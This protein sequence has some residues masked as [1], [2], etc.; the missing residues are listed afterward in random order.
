MLLSIKLSLPQS[1]ISNNN[2]QRRRSRHGDYFWCKGHPLSDSLWRTTAENQSHRHI[3][4]VHLLESY[5][6]SVSNNNGKY[7]TSKFKNEEDTLVKRTTFDKQ[8]VVD[9]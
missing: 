4:N 2:R 9:N 1:R 5:T 8:V 7:E 6:E 3:T